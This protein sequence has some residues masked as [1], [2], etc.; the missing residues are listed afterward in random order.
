MLPLKP[1]GFHFYEGEAKWVARGITYGPFRPDAGGLPYPSA[2]RLRTDFAAIAAA[3][4]NT[5][6]LY[7]FPDEALAA[8]AAEYGLRL[9]LDI[10]WPK[11]LDVYGDPERQA[12][13]L[14]MTEERLRRI[15]S[16][17]NLM[18]VLLGNE[19]P[20]D[21]VRWAGSRRVLSF[22]HR[23]Y[24]RAKELVPE[25]PI[26]YANYPSTEFLQPNFF[27][28]LGFNVYLENPDVFRRYLAR[29]RLQYPEKPLLLSE[30]GLD[31]CQHGESRQAELLGGCL[32]T[33]YH[34]GMAG[35]F[36]FAWTDEWH[37]G[38]FDIKTWT[39]GLVDEARQP[40]PALAVVRRCFEQAPR[41]MERASWP[42]VSVVVATYNGARTLRQCLESLGRLN[43]PNYEVV[44]VDDGS[45]DRTL[46]ILKDFPSTIVVRQQNYGLSVARNS[47]IQA[48]RGQIVAFTDSD[49]VADPDWLYHL[50]VGME[51]EGFTGIGGPNL[52][53]PEE[54]FVPR[55]IAL[56]PGHATHVLINEYEAEHVPGCNMAF[57]REALLKIG[58]F[59][60]I[61]RK[62]GDDVDVIWRLQ[63]SGH[64]I[65]FSTAAYVWHYRR[66]T[67]KGYLKQQIGYGEAEAILLWK[68]PHRFND[69]GQ[70]IWRGVV[71]S[72]RESSAVLG[73]P[74]VH[75]GIFGSADFQCIYERPAGMLSY[76]ITSVEW[77]V[78][79]IG[80]L[81]CGGFSAFSLR[82]GMIGIA[83]ALSASGLRAW[84]RWSNDQRYPLTYLPMAWLLWTIQPIWRGWSR[85]WFRWKTHTPPGVFPK[86]W[87][88]LVCGP[89]NE[90]MR[91]GVL[92]Y[93]SEKGP[94]RVAVLQ[95]LVQRMGQL[96]W[97]C[98]PNTGWEPWD[99]TVVLSWWYKLRLT[100]AEENHGQEKRLLRL[101]LVLVP[102]SLFYLAAVAGVVACSALV[103]Q[104]PYWGRVL[105]IVLLTGL[106]LAYRKA[107]RARLMVASLADAVLEEAGFLVVDKRSCLEHDEMTPAPQVLEQFS[108]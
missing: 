13:C 60:P 75:Y 49:C 44:V 73:G 32:E 29:L 64:R 43:Y 9:L 17:P 15:Q 1:L 33:A 63:D 77:W 90:R 74:N 21:L 98:S 42:K 26:G 48:A 105:M 92:Q 50:V 70:S 85:Y 36:V 106:W 28:F 47:G 82:L 89:I 52:T 40:K 68:H 23:L 107:R 76:L 38:G 56:A 104:E 54:R 51:Q 102:T 97:F 35:A 84:G 72:S 27:D 22:L 8:T 59:N 39:F 103:I 80:L 79:C 19:I 69:R 16:W 99:L 25:L 45:T 101:R 7:E 6:R 14:R 24:V 87:L 86:N 10:P 108:K 4:A 37:T 83:M 61:Y 100:S 41:C 96:H 91:K 12:M 65:G 66:P 5:L 30:V 34:V 11:H 58:G 88:G 18:G 20:A 93:W 81:L 53:P 71:Y 46:E 55:S 2:D 57:R 95:M 78:A 62:A 3:G 94:S 31:T 67:L